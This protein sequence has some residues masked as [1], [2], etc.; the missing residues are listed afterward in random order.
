MSRS[1][2]R[3]LRAQHFR[4][5]RLR[6]FVGNRY[7]AKYRSIKRRRAGVIVPD[8]TPVCDLL[9]IPEAAIIEPR[10]AIEHA[11]PRLRNVNAREHGRQI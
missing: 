10:Q 11:T 3:K 1:I 6:Y 7:V 9:R 8:H 5:K 4:A 2:M